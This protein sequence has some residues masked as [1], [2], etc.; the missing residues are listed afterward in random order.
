MRQGDDAP[1]FVFLTGDAAS[2][3]VKDFL[4]AVN[5]EVLVK[6]FSLAQLK[7]VI[8]EECVVPPVS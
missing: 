2:D 5:A 3:E 8:P 6:P 4:D 1:P 7:S